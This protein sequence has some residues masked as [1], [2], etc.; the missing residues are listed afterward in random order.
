[1]NPFGYPRRAGWL[2]DTAE[3]PHIPDLF[4][5]AP[6]GVSLVPRCMARPCV[7]RHNVER[8]NVRAA[9]MYQASGVKH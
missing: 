2:A 4:V 3:A 7:A 5:A 8:V 1:M 6:K 9:S